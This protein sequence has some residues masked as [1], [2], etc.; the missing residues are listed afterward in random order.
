MC[1]THFSIYLT[2]FEIT[3][4]ELRCATFRNLYIEHL[5]AVQILLPTHALIN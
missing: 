4:Q 1:P 5:I 3:E 2:V